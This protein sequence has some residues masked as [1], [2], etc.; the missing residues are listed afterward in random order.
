MTGAGL[1]P[2]Q[3][4]APGVRHAEEAQDREHRATV[5]SRGDWGRRRA[6]DG[7]TRS[8]RP[9]VTSVRDAHD[10]PCRVR[11]AVVRRT[12]RPPGR[13]RVNSP[14][15]RAFRRRTGDNRTRRESRPEAGSARG[16]RVPPPCERLAVGEFLDRLWIPFG[17]LLNVAVAYGLRGRRENASRSSAGMRRILPGVDALVPKGCPGI[18]GGRT[19][20][21]TAPRRVVGSPE[22]TQYEDDPPPCDAPH[23]TPRADPPGITGQPLVPGWLGD[24]DPPDHRIGRREFPRQFMHF[25]ARYLGCEH[26]APVTALRPGEWLSGGDD[27]ELGGAGACPHRRDG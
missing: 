27:V 15:R 14:R 6:V 26:A 1:P 9:V 2:K 17:R 21:A 11:R 16:V 4:R 8:A 20:T 23:L 5:G 24:D 22:Y 10:A 7:P 13:T 3:A 25:G 12:S 19:T 18:P